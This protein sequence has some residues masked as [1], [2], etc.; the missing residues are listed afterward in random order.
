MAWSYL[1]VLLSVVIAGLL[2]IMLFPLLNGALC[3]DNVADQCELGTIVLLII[4]LPPVGMIL[5]AIWFRLGWEWVAVLSS[6]LFTLLWLSGLFGEVGSIVLLLLAGP[7]I[8]ALA[9]H[10]GRRRPAWV[11]WVIG[12]VTVLTV[13][14]VIAAVFV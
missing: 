3:D 1:G 7:V 11:P 10:P 14:A 9:T 13:G 8:A 2:A 6:L 4:L 5:P 12:L